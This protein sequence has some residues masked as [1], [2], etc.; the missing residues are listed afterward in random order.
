M[1]LEILK[2]AQR[3]LP[4]YFAMAEWEIFPSHIAHFPRTHFD[5][6]FLYGFASQPSPGT[7]FALLIA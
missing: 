6:L 7:D 5:R 1:I 3:E 4:D 2:G